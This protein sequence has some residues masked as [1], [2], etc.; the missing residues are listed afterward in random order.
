M[1][2]QEKPEAVP[3]GEL[4]NNLTLMV[5]R[6]LVGKIA[7]GTRVNAIGIYSIYQVST[8]PCWNSTPGSPTA[9]TLARLRDSKKLVEPFRLV[10]GCMSRKELYSEAKALTLPDS[11]QPGQCSKLPH[12]LAFK[13]VSCSRQ[14]RVQHV[15]LDNS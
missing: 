13:H 8:Q 3:T 12:H 2:L 1:C 14:N 7:P 10:L 6:H 11:R 5:D 9:M 4:P 15:I